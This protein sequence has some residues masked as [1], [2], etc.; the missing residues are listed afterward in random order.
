MV[1]ESTRRAGPFAGNGVTTSFAFNFKTNAKEDLLVVKLALGVETDLVLDSDYSVTL[2]SNQEDSPGG[3]ITY[4]ISGSPLA[5]GESLTVISDLA[6]SQNADL[7]NLGAFYP[8][9]IEDA[10]DRA[11]MLI[12]QLNEALSRAIVLQPSTS[13]VAVELPTPAAGQAIGWN[14]TGNALANIT[15]PGALTVTSLGN[16]LVNAANAAAARTILGSTA[17]G[18]ALFIAASAAAGRTAISAAA[19][20]ANTDIT[21]LSAP[22]LGAATATTQAAA[23]NTTKVATTAMVQ[24]AIATI[25][26]APITKSY[27][28]TDQTITSAGALTLAHGMAAVPALVQAFLVC[29]TGELGYTAGDVLAVSCDGDSSNTRSSGTSL[30]LDATNINVRFGSTASSVFAI[31][32]KTTGATSATTNGNWKWRIKAWA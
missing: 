3:S 21:S 17:V 18:D 22:A 27:T 11:I 5:T 24:S 32:H 1:P 19:A 31:P 12:G 6:I 23:D 16:S 15:S 14:S 13:G 9:V 30:V 7:P 20:G 26:S 4:P 8:T 29:Q 25:P 10:L 2:N 28:S